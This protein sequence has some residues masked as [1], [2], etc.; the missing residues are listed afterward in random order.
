MSEDNSKSVLCSF[1]KMAERF[2]NKIKYFGFKYYCPVCRSHLR[3]LFPYGSK[4][5]KNAKCP[6]CNVVERHRF[7]WMFFQGHTNLFDGSPKKMLHV[8]PEQEFAGRFQKLRGVDYLSA[9]LNNPR[10]MVKMDISEIQYDDESFDII[11][12]SHVLEHVPDDRKA[13]G[14]FHRVLKAEGWAVIMV[15]VMEAKTV[16]DPSVTDPAEREKLFGQF[17]HVRRYGPDFEERLEDAGFIVKKM[18]ARDVL[19][20]SQIMHFALSE[21]DQEEAPV[22]F[23]SKRKVRGA[24]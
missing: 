6:V 19:S 23:C 18:L 20:E 15:P 17:D 21:M 12:C 1:N 4:K 10:A 16:E 11:Y 5:R 2:R 3:L 9:D 22:Y 14:E 13:I 7:I 8:A 24:W